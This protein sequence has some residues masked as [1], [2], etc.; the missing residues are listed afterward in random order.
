MMIEVL[1]TNCVLTKGYQRTLLIDLLNF[2]W[3]AIPNEVAELLKEEAFETIKQDYLEFYTLLCDKDIIISI[4]EEDRELLNP[5]L[6]D[7][8]S[9]SVIEHALIDWEEGVSS[10]DIFY[11]IQE[12]KE[13]GCRNL[14]LRFY[15]EVS[16]FFIREIF[17][18]IEGTIIE[19][20]DIVVPYTMLKEH[21]E[22]FIS[23]KETNGRFKELLAHG[24]PPHL[25][26]PMQKFPWVF[27]TQETIHDCTG[28]GKVSSLYFCLNMSHYTLSQ[29][30]NNCLYKKLGVDIQGNIKNCPSSKKQ[31]G[32]VGCAPLKEIV[33]GQDFAHLG[34]IRKD[35]VKI[36]SDCEF[37]SICSDCR[38]YTENNGDEYAKPKSCTYNPYIA[39]WEHEEGFVS[40][41]HCGVKYHENGLK[42]DHTRI[43]K[44]YQDLYE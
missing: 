37:R 30:F 15:K 24:C 5:M 32:K 26:Q 18:N 6:L 19:A 35:Q 16:P 34:N 25:S 29:N 43:K 20:T 9:P 27:G 22:F 1:A 10:Y 36:C 23:L 39:T 13:L 41:P 28:C 11:L 31:F 7:Y 42:V 4:P 12:L 40:L 8:I 38:V 21:S 2:K 33:F 17:E 44:I 14:S 3:W